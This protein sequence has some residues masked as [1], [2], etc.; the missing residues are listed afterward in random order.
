MMKQLLT[1]QQIIDIARHKGWFSFR[2]GV[3]GNF[4]HRQHRQ[5]CE[6][7]AAKGILKFNGANYT[8][9]SYAFISVPGCQKAAE[10]H[11]LT[12]KG[13]IGSRFSEQ[14]VIDII[15]RKGQV[16]AQRKPQSRK[17][18]SLSDQCKNL[19]KKGKIALK[20]KTDKTVVYELT[21]G[22]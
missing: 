20:F 16:V 10:K 17:Q 2:R 13:M 8:E 11:R 6:A 9:I 14:R 22:A 3:R 7:L 21:E 1:E 15:K 5:I 19:M 12:K 18:T 4:P